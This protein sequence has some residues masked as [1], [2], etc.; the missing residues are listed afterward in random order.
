M[1]RAAQILLRLEVSPDPESKLISVVEEI[2]RELNW[3]QL[4]AAHSRAGRNA[5]RPARGRTCFTIYHRWYAFC[6]RNRT[7]H[8]GRGRDAVRAR[9]LCLVLDWYAPQHPDRPHITLEEARGRGTTLS[10]AVLAAKALRAA[11]G[12]RELQVAAGDRVAIMLL[13]SEAFF[14]AFF[15]GAL[16]RQGSGSDLIAGSAR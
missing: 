8:S 16:C 11:H 13:T 15:C 10:Y 3:R 2:V 12:L 9:T 4:A 7:G 5:A 14:V 1:A 6:P